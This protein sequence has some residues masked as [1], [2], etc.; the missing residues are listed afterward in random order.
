M[1]MNMLPCLGEGG[2]KKEDDFFL[3]LPHDLWVLSSLTSDQASDSPSNA[4]PNPNPNPN[5]T[6]VVARAKA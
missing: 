4:N 2:G 1:L 6:L 3:V 5:P